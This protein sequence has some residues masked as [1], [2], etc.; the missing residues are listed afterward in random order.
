MKADNIYLGALYGVVLGDYSPNKALATAAIYGAS[1]I[2]VHTV[3]DHVNVT[4]AAIVGP[5]SAELPA[6][7]YDGNFVVA[8]WTGSPVIEAPNPEDVHVIKNR[9]TYKSGY[10]KKQNTGS[11]VIVSSKHGDSELFFKNYDDPV[12]VFKY[13]Y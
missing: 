5:A 7:G 10:Y 6:N 9:Y 8:S 4:S 1:K 13:M 2:R 3:G 12:D 11:N